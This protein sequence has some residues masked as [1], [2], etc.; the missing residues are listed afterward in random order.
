MNRLGEEVAVRRD[1]QG[2]AS[3][4]GSRRFSAYGELEWGWW[5][6]V[7]EDGSEFCG[8][9]EFWEEEGLAVCMC[10]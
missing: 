1:G 9:W 5:V 6:E 8:L 10:V 3:V 4:D 7:V 2:L